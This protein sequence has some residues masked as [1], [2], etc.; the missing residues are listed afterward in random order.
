[1][2]EYAKTPLVFSIQEDT[3]LL[4]VSNINT[5]IIYNLLMNDKSVEYIKFLFIRI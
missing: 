3:I 2:N 1:M 5:E 4:N